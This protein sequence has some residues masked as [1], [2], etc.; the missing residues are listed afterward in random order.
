MDRETYFVRSL[1]NQY[2]NPASLTNKYP[3]PNGDI[4][5]QTNSELEGHTGRVQLNLNQAWQNHRLNFIGGFEVKQLETKSSQSRLYAYDDDILISQPIDYYTRFTTNPNNS[6]S[7]AASV[8]YPREVTGFLDR[9]LSYYANG[10]YTFNDRYVF[11]ASGRFDNTNFFG[12]KANQR[13]LPLWSTGFKWNI[14][15]EEFFRSDLFD[16]LSFRATY[17]YNGN[18]NKDITAY[19]TIKFYTDALTK[20]TSAQVVNPP[21]PELRWEKVGMVNLGVVFALKK[22]VLSGTIEY[23]SKKGSDLIGEATVDPT[24][25]VPSFKGNLADIKGKGVDVQLT[26]KI[27]NNK[28]CYR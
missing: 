12:I 16:Q 18:V 4:F 25:G 20:A 23:F 15:R 17:G 9:F 7:N 13:I 19:T 10:T 24:L 27:I 1:V 3:V 14:S 22:N 21:N 2:Y 28:L 5:D 26:G 8:P 11:S 6:T